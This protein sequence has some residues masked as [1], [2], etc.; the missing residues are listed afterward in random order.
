MSA[1]TKIFVFKM[2]EIIYTA[3]F[4]ALG[5]LLVILMIFMFLPGKKSQNPEPSAATY[6]PGIYTSSITLNNQGIDVEIVVDNSHINSV[7]FVNLNE[8]VAAM[9]P[10]MES[11]LDNIG[12]QVCEK[13]STE[14][15]TYS[16]D[17][18]YT[19]MVL[20]DAIKAALSQAAIQ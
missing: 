17:M 20:L 13:Q 3:I 5:I 11:V 1:N 6:T 10:L 12:K 9:Y 16:D 14:S 4:V 7:R 8:S 18:K 19:S 15:I 2:K